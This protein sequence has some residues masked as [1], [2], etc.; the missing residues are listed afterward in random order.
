M[1]ISLVL[2]GFIGLLGGVLAQG[3]RVEE[4]WVRRVP[5]NITAAYMVLFNPGPRPVVII[6]AETPI[7]TRTEFH[8]SVPVPGSARERLD[9]VGMQRVHRLEVPARGRLE[10]LPGRFHLM[11]YGLREKRSAPLREGE[12]VRITLLLEG[13]GRFNM[14]APAQMR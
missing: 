5:G 7:A 10:L 11:L 1:K 9:T 3:L 2:I 4:A 8:Q 13:G 14:V 6:G 12:S